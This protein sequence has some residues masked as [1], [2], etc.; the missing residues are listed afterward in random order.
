M[1]AEVVLCNLPSSEM[2]NGQVAIVTSE[3]DFNRTTGQGKVTT[4][5]LG[6]PVTEIN[7]DLEH[8]R[9]ARFY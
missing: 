3:Q 2:H 5:T 4:K 9:L 8:L 6:A 7:V 1:R